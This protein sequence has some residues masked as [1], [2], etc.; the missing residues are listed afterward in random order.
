MINIGISRLPPDAEYIAWIDMDVQWV[1]PDWAEATIAK[2]DHYMFVQMFRDAIDLGPDFEVMNRHQGFIYSWI[3][4]GYQY[5]RQ[6]DEPYSPVTGSQAHPGY[7]WA[8]RREALDHVGSLIDWGLL[9]SGDYFMAAALI[10]HAEKSIPQGMTD[11]FIRKIMLWQERAKQYIRE[12]VGYLSATLYHFFHGRK[13]DRNYPGRDKLLAAHRYDP[14]LDLKLDSQ[15]LYQLTDNNPR[16]RDA[17]RA[18]FRARNE[19]AT[20]L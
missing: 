2:L 1:R 5:P 14:D 20:D 11:R 8:A 17:V 13:L 9:G 18:Y 4:K 12:D 7:C 16:L 3:K 15:M 19:D 6:K 10:S